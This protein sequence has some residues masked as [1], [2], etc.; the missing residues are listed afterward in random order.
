MNNLVDAAEQEYKFITAKELAKVGRKYGLRIEE[1]KEDTDESPQ[2]KKQS[3]TNIINGLLEKETQDAL[4]R[5]M[6]DAEWNRSLI[7]RAENYEIAKRKKKKRKRQQKL[8]EEEEISSSSSN[9]L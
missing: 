3:L 2:K 1:T 5:A 8:E 9:E 4:A 6:M 7:V